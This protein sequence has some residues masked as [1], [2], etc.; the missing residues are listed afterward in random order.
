MSLSHTFLSVTINIVSVATH[1]GNPNQ[2]SPL[3]HLQN[4]KSFNNVLIYAL[5]IWDLRL[6]V[7]FFLLVH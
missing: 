3:L 6:L 2:G 4:E 7:L 5:G 1:P